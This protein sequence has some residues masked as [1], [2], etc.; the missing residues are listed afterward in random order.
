MPTYHQQ[1]AAG[2]R[3]FLLAGSASAAGLADVLGT[4][5]SLVV[6]AE[7][8]VRTSWLDTFD[9]RLAA[10]GMALRYD[11]GRGAPTLTAVGA[12]LPLVTAVA[13]QSWPRLGYDVLPDAAEW[14]DVAGRVYPR[15][16]LPVARTHGGIRPVRLLDDQQKTIATGTLEHTGNADHTIHLLRL[17]PLRGYAAETDTAGTLIAAVDGVQPDPGGTG[18]TAFEPAPEPGADRFPM[19]PTEPAAHAVAGAL[20]GWL[21]I[22]DDNVGGVADDLDSEFLHD[23]RVAVRRARSMLKVA[24][25]VLPADFVAAYAPE[26]RWLGDLTTPIRDLDVFLLGLHSDA[27]IV[28]TQAPV[29][30]PFVTELHR[31]RK[32][33][34]RA[35]RRG[36][37]SARYTA[38]ARDYRARLIELQVGEPEVA[39]TAAAFA[40]TRVEQLY[41]KV[42]KRGDAITPVSPSESLHDLRKRC[43]E[44]RYVLDAFR[45]VLDPAAYAPAMRGL[46][47]LQ[48]CLGRLQ[49]AHVQRELIHDTAAE[50]MTGAVVKAPTLLAMGAATT[51]IGLREEAVRAEFADQWARFNR[52]KVRRAMRTLV[53]TARESGS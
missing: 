39:I 35:L 36:L 14:S 15:A 43:K 34:L 47:E 10:A 52:P 38:L 5:F 4:A 29:I 40:A 16:L 25:D 3:D 50:L 21:G 24:G 18:I 19:H 1:R 9:H 7:R 22:L 45:P 23:F 26:L 17:T 12:D 48:E 31:R 2:S 42:R 13:K 30:R 28:D 53:A 11:E 41:R 51:G 49:D 8:R 33:E 32:A 37:R 46:K 27:S 44:L 6:G 20:L